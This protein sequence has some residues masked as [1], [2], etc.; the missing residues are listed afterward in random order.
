MPTGEAII[1]LKFQ[2]RVRLSS[3]PLRRIC[4]AAYHTR[5]RIH[6]PQ[7][8][9]NTVQIDER[10]QTELESAVFRRLLRHLQEHPD[11]Q[12]IDLMITA[13]FCRNCLAKWLQEAADQRNILIDEAKARKLVYGEPYESWKSKY[14]RDATPEQLQAFEERQRRQA[15]QKNG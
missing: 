14:Q 3:I 4:P 9:P 12:N 7:F 13:D 2:L 10:T 15:A 5:I 1:A 6:F 8:I 11:V